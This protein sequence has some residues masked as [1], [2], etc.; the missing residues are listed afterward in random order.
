MNT[1]VNE[2]LWMF[3]LAHFHTYVEKLHGQ[4]KEL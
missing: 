3:L 2:S 1:R 4:L